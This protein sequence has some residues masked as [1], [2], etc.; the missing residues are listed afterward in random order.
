MLEGTPGKPYGGLLAHFNVVEANM[1]YRRQEVTKLLEPNE[2]L[3]S[4]TVFPR[5]IVFLLH[6]W[7]TLI[8]LHSFK[9]TDLSSIV[10]LS[11]SVC[12]KS[13]NFICYR[14]G[15]PDFTDPPTTPTPETGASRS[16]FFP[17]EAIYP[18]HPRFKT[19]TRNIRER[20]QEKVAINIP[21]KNYL[22][23]FFLGFLYAL[24]FRNLER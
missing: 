22:S 18:G 15:A 17:D 6:F 14:I 2:V 24:Y 8:L 10:I 3:M 9:V 4:L 20:R 13:I 12:Y 16:L 11:F 7:N 5:W 21:S 19:L 1:R 23:F